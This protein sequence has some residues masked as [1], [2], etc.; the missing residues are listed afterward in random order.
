MN[1]FEIENLDRTIIVIPTANL[2]EFEFE[3]IEA[4]AE[5]ILSLLENAPAKNV[6]V[7]FHKI[8]YLG[9]TALSFF[10]KVWKRVSKQ[11]GLMALCNVSENEK[12]VLKTTRL[13]N[14][15]PVCGSREEAMRMVRK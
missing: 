1:L 10:V 6:V 8:D 4:G 15:W 13:D 5:A 9:S 14:L 7:D 2:N 11:N 12:E 3:R